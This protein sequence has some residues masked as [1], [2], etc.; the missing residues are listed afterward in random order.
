[1]GCRSKRRTTSRTGRGTRAGCTPAAT[2]GTWRSEEHTSELQSRENL[3]CRL[4][5][6]KKKK[7]RPVPTSRYIHKPRRCMEENWLAPRERANLE[8]R[9]AAACRP[10]VGPTGSRF[11][12]FNDTATTEIYTLSLRDALPISAELGAWSLLLALL[13]GVPVGTIAAVRQDRKSTRLNSSHVKISYA[14]LCL[15]KKK[16]KE[17]K[18]TSQYTKTKK[19]K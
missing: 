9:R 16:N 12:F 6:E 5:L 8:D 10:H 15:K 18:S 1:M 13:V 2:T 11:F 14:V 3:V 7:T 4:L 17:G 19:K